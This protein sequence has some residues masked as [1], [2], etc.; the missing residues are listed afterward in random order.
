MLRP[1]LGYCSR[2]LPRHAVIAAASGAQARW[3]HLAWA[4]ATSGR[5][6]SAGVAHRG[7]TKKNQ[8]Q[9]GVILAATV[10]PLLAGVALSYLLSG[11]SK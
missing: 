6:G 2:S 9:T 4:G 3:A 11:S 5:K 1:Y 10:G 8:A 7:S